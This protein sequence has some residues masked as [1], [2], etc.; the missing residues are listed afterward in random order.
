MQR[1]DNK[2]PSFVMQRIEPMDNK[3]RQRIE[4]VIWDV[5]GVTTNF[6]DESTSRSITDR[7]G[8][9]CRFVQN[10]SDAGRGLLFFEEK[11][12][13]MMMRTEKQGCLEILIDEHQKDIISLVK[14][15]NKE[16]VVKRSMY[17]RTKRRCIMEV[18]STTA[19]TAIDRYT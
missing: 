11:I 17:S 6:F 8:K 5:E 9:L 7:I 10:L 19:E 1:M 4:D 15:Y 18:F 16:E 2:R 13:P 12:Y 14:E 3:C